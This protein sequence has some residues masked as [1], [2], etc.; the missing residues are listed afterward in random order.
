MFWIAGEH[1]ETEMIQKDFNQRS[2]RGGNVLAYGL[3]LPGEE[4]R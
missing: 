2:K 1:E 4:K 3:R